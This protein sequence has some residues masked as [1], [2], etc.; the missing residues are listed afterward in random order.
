MAEDLGRVVEGRLI[1]QRRL[2]SSSLATF[3]PAPAGGSPRPSI[4]KL[5]QTFN[6]GQCHLHLDLNQDTPVAD[7][8]STWVSIGLAATQLLG[9]CGTSTGMTGGWI[10]TGDNDHLLV[11]VGNLFGNNV[12]GEA[13]SNLTL[14]ATVPSVDTA[15]S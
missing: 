2:I 4:Y 5:P 14:G 9:A 6:Y 11:T 10:R 12:N 1:A 7:E 8:Q 13:A 3:K 15:R